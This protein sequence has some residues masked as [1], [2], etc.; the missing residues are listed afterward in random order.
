MVLKL[1]VH[2]FNK[3]EIWNK[4]KLEN[5]V[6]YFDATGNIHT[7]I[8]GQSMPYLY[9]IAIH[10]KEK[11]RILSFADFITT[12]HTSVNVSKYLTSIKNLMTDN[13]EITNAT[14]FL[15]APIVV[16]DFSWALI[17]GVQDSFNRC[18]ISHYLHWC[19][20][21]LILDKTGNFKSVIIVY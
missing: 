3:L 14:Q 20:Q 7:K 13:R 18:D 11:K 17:N 1:I 12:C 19:Y 15:I 8:K 5:P 21:V 2:I 16:T 4:I 9:T 6:F 10:D